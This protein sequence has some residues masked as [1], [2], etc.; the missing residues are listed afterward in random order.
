MKVLVLGRTGQLAR[1]LARADWPAEW[2]PEFS[3]R[4]EIDLSLPES[5]AGAVA[6]RGPGLVI[7]AAAYTAVDKAESEP[8][9]AHRINALA[10]GAVAVACAGSN[11]PFVTVSTDYVFDGSKNGA[12]SEDDPTAPTSAYGSSKAQ[13]ERL[14]REASG[15][16]LILRTSWV[17]SATGTNFVRTM[18]RLAGEREI[19]GIVAD[20]RGR[21]TAASDL[22][23]AIVIASEALLRD[24]AFSG[25][26]H[27]ANAGTTT[28]YD[29]A[30]AI[31]E[32]AQARGA[33]MPSLHA[34]STSEYPTP[35]RRP[36]NSEL[37]TDKFE[38]A[39]G[40]TFRHW[41][42]PLAEVLD[43]LLAPV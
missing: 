33:R 13:G 9:L 10:P 12:Y 31:F 41:R 5:A 40:H 20:Q 11:I 18:L 17:F 3:G 43:E 29:F 19:L 4:D 25:T 39:F 32:K 26:Y 15:L 24:P 16:H 34:I 1:E 35:A 42:A 30:S 36:R 7:N 2:Q 22:A 8:D 23:A 6:D 21:P 27:V 37:A 14:V 38:R 28:W